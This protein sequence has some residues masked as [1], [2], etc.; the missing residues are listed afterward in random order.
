MNYLSKKN[1]SSCCET[2]IHLKSAL[3]VLFSFKE[4]AG[5]CLIVLPSRGEMT[6]CRLIWDHLS[7][8]ATVAE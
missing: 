5:L 3:D 1:W 7:I 4:M 2:S 8:K 6:S